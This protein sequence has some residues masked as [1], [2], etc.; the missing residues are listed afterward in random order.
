[1]LTM[2]AVVKVYD[3]QILWSCEL[4]MKKFYNLGAWF[5]SEEVFVF[6]YMF[7]KIHTDLKLAVRESVVA[8]KSA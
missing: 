6:L 1:M 8:L 2:V 4:S 5:Q 7:I 3:E